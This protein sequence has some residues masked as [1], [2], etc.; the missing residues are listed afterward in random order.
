MSPALATTVV[1]ASG[2]IGVTENER[3]T[4][5]A[6]R[7]LL[8][9]AWSAL[10]VQVPALPKL[11]MPPLVI[12]HTLVVEELKVTLRPE[13][14]VTPPPQDAQVRAVPKLCEPGLAKVMVCGEAG[15]T[16]VEAAEAAPVSA[17]LLVAVTVKVYGTPLVSPVTVI[18][19]PAPVPVAPPGLAVTV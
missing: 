4:C 10:M 1:G 5:G 14:E 17:A 15:I 18:G 16:E 19:E 11:R 13:V 8:L 6:A 7:K 3:L 2:T 12:V 9:P